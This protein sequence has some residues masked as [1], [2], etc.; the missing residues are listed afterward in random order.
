MLVSDLE[1]FDGLRVRANGL[2]LPGGMDFEVWR[3]VGRHV[4]QAAESVSWWVGDW[5]VYGQHTYGDRYQKAIAQTSLDYQTLRNY[6]WVANKFPL[7]RRRDKLSLGHHSEV[8]ALIEVEQDTWLAR[9]ERLGWSRNELRRR[10]RAARLAGRR[11]SRPSPPAL[12][13]VRLEVSRQQH[14]RWQAAAA[15]RDR[16]VDDWIVETLDQAASGTAIDD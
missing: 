2:V 12:Q 13:S 10:L 7:S 4:L 15:Q 9:A 3:R 16:A 14:H 1:A 11:E 6:A 5:L 8:A